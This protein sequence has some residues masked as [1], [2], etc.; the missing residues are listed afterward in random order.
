MSSLPP[1]F[2][3]SGDIAL[4]RRYRWAKASLDAGETAEAC[5][6]LR[7]TVAAAPGWAPAWKLLADALLAAGKDEEARPALEEAARLDPHGALGAKI[8]LARLGA[9]SPNDAIQPGYV[10]ALFDDYAHRFDAHLTRVLSYRGPEAVMSALSEVC[11]ARGWPMRFENGLD[12]G[13]GTGLMGEP[14]RPF[15]A[16]LAGVDLSPLML[17]K[18]RAKLLYD[19]LAIGDITEFLLAEPACS[20][21]LILAADVLVYLGDLAPLLRAV[22]MKLRPLGLFA[23]TTQS[24]QNDPRPA[25]FVLGPDSRFSHSESYIRATAASFSLDVALLARV[26]T[27]QDA[28]RDVPGLV[29]VL[30]PSVDEGDKTELPSPRLCVARTSPEQTGEQR[31][32]ASAEQKAGPT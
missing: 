26:V 17:A 18:A 3:S 10:A 14:V 25:G 21:D 16:E 32:D 20:L 12:L 11:G 23:F 30:T 4:D 28:G 1:G 31:G 5:E 2:S 15:V 13:C 27:R 6:I 8:D 7:Q 29:V 22:A 24:T 9:L 19:R